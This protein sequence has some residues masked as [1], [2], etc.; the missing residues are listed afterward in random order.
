MAIWTNTLFM[1]GYLWWTLAAGE[2]RY[3][4]IAA[5]TVSVVLTSA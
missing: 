1:L 3:A 2:G 5:L 4:L